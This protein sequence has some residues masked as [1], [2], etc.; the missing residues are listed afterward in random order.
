MIRPVITP[1]LPNFGVL[2]GVGLAK[3]R[4]TLQHWLL[5]SVYMATLQFYCAWH[6][7]VGL[8]MP[9]YAISSMITLKA[10]YMWDRSYSPFGLPTPSTQEESTMALADMHKYLSL[11]D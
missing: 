11:S 4:A 8:L 5:I 9:R 10:L 1:V 3:A 2:G 6:L 7:D